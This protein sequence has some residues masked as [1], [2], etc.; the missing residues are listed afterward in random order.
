LHSEPIEL[1]WSGHATL[2]TA[3][4]VFWISQTH[5]DHREAH[6]VGGDEAPPRRAI[7]SAPLLDMREFCLNIQTRTPAS[8]QMMKCTQE[9]LVEFTA[10]RKNYCRGAG[11][12]ATPLPKCDCL[13]SARK[14]SHRIRE[15]ACTC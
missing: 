10:H 13:A 2:R 9:Q 4:A 12:V 6:T 14:Q 11:N 8:R 1:N 15:D 3:D 7:S 5:S